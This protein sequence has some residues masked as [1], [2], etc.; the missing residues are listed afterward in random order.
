MLLFSSLGLAAG[1]GVLGFQVG[2]E[3]VKLILSGLLSL[4]GKKTERFQS[5]D[6]VNESAVPAETRI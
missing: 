2:Q 5:S 4:L 6:D 1:F 3:T